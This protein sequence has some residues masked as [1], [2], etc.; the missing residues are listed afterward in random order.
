MKRLELTIDRRYAE[1]CESCGTWLQRRDTGAFMGDIG[2]HQY[3]TFA[4][5][6]EDNPELFRFV[7]HDPERCRLLRQLGGAE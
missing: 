6:C 1:P 2:A 5:E 3:E 7:E 4:I